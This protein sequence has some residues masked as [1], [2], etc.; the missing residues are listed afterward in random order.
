MKKVLAALMAVLMAL[1]LTSCGEKTT[2]Y[3]YDG[4]TIQIPE[5]FVMKEMETSFDRCWYDENTEIAL[6]VDHY[7][8]EWLQENGYGDF[9]IEDIAYNIG[10]GYEIISENAKGT[11][12][13]KKYISPEGDDYNVFKFA[14]I[15]QTNDGYWLVVLD[16][17]EEERSTYEPKFTKWF[18]TVSIKD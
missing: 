15:Y 14:N 3:T 9:T 16:C 7:T 10:Y 13:E 8:A 12:F 2:T 17:M 11:T 5:S 4:M 1:A 18:Q 6:W